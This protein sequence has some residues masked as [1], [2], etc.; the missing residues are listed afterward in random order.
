M[1]A[2][3]NQ[4]TMARAGGRHSRLTALLVL[5]LVGGT[6]LSGQTALA[7]D[8]TL[9]L[10]EAVAMALQG[11]PDLQKQALAHEAAREDASDQK[12]QR[13]GRLSLVSSYNH[14]N[15]PRT[16]APLTPSSLGSDPLSIPTTRDLFT[17]GI[18]YELELFTGF[19]RKRAVE[20][21]GLQEE[22]A[23][24]ALKLSRE[25]LIYNVRSLYVKILSLQAQAQA[26][27]TY[28][29]ALQKLHDNVTHELELGRKA[30]IDQ[31][32]AAADLKSA[33]AGLSQIESN[34]S[35]MKGSLANLLGIEQVP[36]LVDIDCS[37]GAMVRVEDDF[38]DQ[39]VGS[40]RL[41]N[42]QLAV[43][44]SHKLVQK[45]SGSLYPQLV[46]TSAY[47]SNFGPNDSSHFDSGTWQDETVWQAGLSL[48]W[49]IFDFGSR[50]ARIQQA[51][52]LE[53]QSV[54]DQDKTTLELRQSL[55]EATTRINAVLDDYHSAEAEFAL[56][57]ETAA[58][59]QVRFDRGAADIN[60]LLYAQARNLLAE[61]RL[62]GARYD[63][64]AAR[65]YLNY[66]LE[67][68]ENQ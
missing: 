45:T 64:S 59:E 58:I 1:N 14:Y 39:L 12:S 62:I 48:K 40:Q 63:Y 47:G 68:G 9:T 23:G 21:S 51:R 27:T 34:I 35:L 67:N 52:I 19:T 7:Q 50:K 33:R 61:S 10:D 28:V 57:S 55:H 2:S 20:I 25:Q 56:T 53:R 60:D 32:K 4:T 66:L 49:N 42:A 46:L 41:Q 17:A 26:Q 6:L 11:N 22:M 29:A 43:N 16:L 54:Y 31:L 3:T 24:I 36:E 65:Y 15:L 30:R 5:L 37:A 44:R 38:S 18:V 8:Q 13:F